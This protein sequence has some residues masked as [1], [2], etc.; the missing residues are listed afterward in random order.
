MI[1]PLLVAMATAT[2]L[3]PSFIDYPNVSA[4]SPL[5][6]PGAPYGQVK[7]AHESQDSFNPSDGAL[8]ME[9][10]GQWGCACR[11]EGGYLG[12]GSS[13]IQKA[14]LASA[15]TRTA[16]PRK[17]AAPNQPQPN[18][19]TNYPTSAQHEGHTTAHYIGGANGG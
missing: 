3:E 6:S 19:L 1:G 2:G 12:G 14:G 10:A 9:C 11:S 5:G 15:L 8:M 17:I 13:S 16:A 4:C 7:L 18:P